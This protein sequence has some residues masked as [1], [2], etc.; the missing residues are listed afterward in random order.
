MD[1]LNL[2]NK[3]KIWIRIKNYMYC[4]I[5]LLVLFTLMLLGMVILNVII[6]KKVYTL[7]SL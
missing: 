1:N 4:A 7:S 2:L 5:S 6:L 3:D